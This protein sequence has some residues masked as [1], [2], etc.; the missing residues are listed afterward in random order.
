MELYPVG[1]CAE[2]V[3]YV[4]EI[5]MVLR[6]GPG[7]VDVVDLETTIGWDEAG[8]DGRK[9]NSNDFAGGILVGKVTFRE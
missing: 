3:S 9:I 4:D 7:L 1:N 8:L 5:K 6:I 2:H